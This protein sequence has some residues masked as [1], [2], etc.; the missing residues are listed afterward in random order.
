MKGP[1]DETDSDRYILARTTDPLGAS[2]FTAVQEQLGLK[3]D[4][5]REPTE[6]LVADTGFEHEQ[7]T[8]GSRLQ[9]CPTVRPECFRYTL[10][11]RSLARVGHTDGFQ[12]AADRRCGKPGGDH[13]LAQKQPSLG[14]RDGRLH[15]NA[16]QPISVIH[17]FPGVNG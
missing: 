3:L 12:R 1:G 17:G 14:M 6:M 2:I 7:T 8:E 16:D 13:Q 5:V 9:T 15:A 4:P 10:A 11:N